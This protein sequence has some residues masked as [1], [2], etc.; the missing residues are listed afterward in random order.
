MAT[1]LKTE[2]H[3]SPVSAKDLKI[4]LM[5]S[6]IRHGLK[7]VAKLGSYCRNPEAETTNLSL[8]CTFTKNQKTSLAD[9]YNTVG[10]NEITQEPHQR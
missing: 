7:L 6:A 8:F 1:S 2:T 9:G 5:L 4:Q 10:V 3:Q